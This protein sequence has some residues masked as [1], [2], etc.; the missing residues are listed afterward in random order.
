MRNAKLWRHRAV[1]G[2]VVRRDS[3]RGVWIGRKSSGSPSG[4]HG[5]NLVFIGPSLD[6]SDKEFVKIIGGKVDRRKPPFG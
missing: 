5:G 6:G 2:I 1:S 4:G 3:A